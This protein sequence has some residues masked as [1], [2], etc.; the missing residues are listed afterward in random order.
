MLIPK[1]NF[2][3]V[4]IG[5]GQKVWPREHTVRLL[6]TAQKQR[7]DRFSI[8]STLILATPVQLTMTPPNPASNLCGDRL[9]KPIASTNCLYLAQ[10]MSIKS[11][12]II[13]QYLQRSIEV[14][15]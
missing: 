13:E 14:Y 15:V 11:S 7:R 2:V 10:L 4:A 1:L 9:T 6:S 8:C 3:V 5:C 12:M